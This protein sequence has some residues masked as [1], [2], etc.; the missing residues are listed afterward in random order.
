LL[1]SP[2]KLHVGKGNSNE[3]G[4]K[5][6]GS[7]WSTGETVY[8]IPCATSYDTFDY[9]TCRFDDAHERI[10]D[11]DGN[12]KTDYWNAFEVMRFWGPLGRAEG[13]C[14]L[15]RN[16]GPD[17]TPDTGD[18][19]EA[20]VCDLGS[21]TAAPPARTVPEQTP[22]ISD[23][24]GFPLASQIVQGF[25]DEKGLNGASLIVV[26]R[27]D[28]VVFHE[29]WGEFA[30]GRVSLVAMANK[31]ISAGVL[32][33]LH[34]EGL[35]DIDAPVA[36]VVDWGSGNPEIT[37]AQLI[38]N[39]SG[40]L[41]MMDDPMFMPYFCIWSHQA[42]LKECAEMLFTTPDDDA[43]LIPPDTEFRYGGAQWQVAGAV[44]EV[45]SG[46]SWAEL[47]DEIYVQPCGL[48]VLGFTH[49]AQFGMVMAYPSAFNGDPSTLEP[50]E[51][52][53]IGG[54]AY[55]TTDDFAKLLLMHLRDGMCGENRVHSTELLERMH[56]DRIARVY[57]GGV[58]DDG[59]PGD[60]W[61]YGLGLWVDRETGRRNSPGGFG[62]MP[63]LDLDDGYGA[64]IVLESTF[65]DGVELSEL[66]ADAIH[67]G[68][69][70]TRN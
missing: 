38:S 62:A 22:V 37:P 23:L 2:G 29:H 46:K 65:E 68:V 3:W 28:G 63:I 60:A 56:E 40:M 26:D 30:P 21:D 42:I 55:T 18:E 1:Y 43:R 16:D 25:V 50:T 9:S 39:S 15:A 47:V 12:I 10:A 64:Y 59:S 32:V 66:T 35:L 31:I 49:P 52:P 13:D 41:G 36:D 5:I 53:Y 48:G 8:L 20:I 67:E 17:L 51:N 6:L 24:S 54:G 70:A 44:A 27:D 61:G 19:S 34:E 7:G 4:G 69:I 57:D 14:T 11:D 45:A 33:H 58:S